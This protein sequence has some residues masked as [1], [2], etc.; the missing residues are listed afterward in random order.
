MRTRIAVAALITCCVAG[1]ASQPKAPVDRYPQRQV[2]ETVETDADRLLNYY[3]YMTGLQGDVLLQEYQRVQGA[4]H[5]DPSD[6]HRMQLIML[7]SSPSA[8]F[9]DTQ[10]AQ[11]LLKAWLEVEYNAYSKLY[12]LALLY[13]NYLS[14]LEGRR[15][16][17]ER[18]GE[19]LREAKAQVQQQDE[20]IARQ[21]SEIAAQK[22][23]SSELQE[24]LNA[25]L[26]ME[27]NLIERGQ[28][29]YP[30]TP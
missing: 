26:E 24:K 29:Q 8:P 27:K 18:A 19:E 25:L 30:E 14:E 9:R 22:Q 28:K 6:F 15:D 5:S 12:P 17:I 3:A 10:L 4:Y 1:C 23:R 13:R 20:Q 7:L 11:N 16:A 21:A 2:V